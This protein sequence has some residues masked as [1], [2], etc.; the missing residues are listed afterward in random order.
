MAGVPKVVIVGG[1]PAGVG[2][3]KQLDSKLDV[4]L[5]ERKV[6]FHNNVPALR[7]VVDATYR[8][9]QFQPYSGLFKS[10]S[11]RVVRG[12]VVGVEGG[13][14][15]L[16]DGQ[17]IAY[18]YL[19]IAT[20]SQ[21]PFPAKLEDL[22][23]VKAGIAK[24]EQMEAVVQRANKILIVGGGP[25]GVEFAGEIKCAF[26]NKDVTIIHRGETLLSNQGGA[27]ALSPAF[28]GGVAD[29]VRDL[30]INLILGDSVEISAEAKRA[31]YEE[32][33]KTLKSSKGKDIQTDL[34]LWCT[35]NSPNTGFLKSSLGAAIGNNGLIKVNGH[36]QVE[37][38]PNVFAIGDVTNVLEP[39]L[40]FVA[41]KHAEVVAKNIVAL[42]KNK[43][44]SAVHKPFQNSSFMVVG[45]NR[46]ISQVGFLP[47]PMKGVKKTGM[48]AT[49]KNKSRLFVDKT[50]PMVTGNPMPKANPNLD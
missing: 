14:V 18:D 48:F 41:S 33:S 39:K 45:P 4:T 3:A 21:N 6:A 19:V 44:A 34:V 30:K 49:L 32:G 36:L 22:N 8:W 31:G 1:G 26:P 43:T 35:G 5:I 10:K 38:H 15:K 7:A 28:T 2:L 12:D 25:V 16:K 46:G 11:G 23:S 27:P 29:I 42:S 13:G 24:Y 40:A 47:W 37:G 20:G 9:Q 17:S 50:W